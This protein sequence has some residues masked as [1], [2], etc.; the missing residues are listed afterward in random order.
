LQIFI[1]CIYHYESKPTKWLYIEK[2]VLD[3][4]LQA[5]S[6]HGGGKN[7]FAQGG[8]TNPSMIDKSIEDVLTALA[9]YSAM[10]P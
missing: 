10:E 1:S 9:D 2:K 8:G 5:L 3:S 6:G 4:A 7:D